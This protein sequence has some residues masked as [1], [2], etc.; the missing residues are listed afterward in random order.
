MTMERDQMEGVLTRSDQC[1]S[2]YTCYTVLHFP[3]A[4]YTFKVIITLLLTISQILKE[5]VP[6]SEMPS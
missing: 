1:V 4:P 5:T 6:S 2:S 3:L